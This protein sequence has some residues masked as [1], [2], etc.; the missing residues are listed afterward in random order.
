[1]CASNQVGDYALFIINLTPQIVNYTNS[2]GSGPQQ[3]INGTWNSTLANITVFIAPDYIY[4][5][6][7]V[8]F[9]TL[10]ALTLGL[11]IFSNLYFHARYKDEHQ[12][13]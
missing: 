9:N 8:L 12:E 2:S 6:D 3:I 10:A 11:F 5:D 7:K 13:L 1:M 4:D